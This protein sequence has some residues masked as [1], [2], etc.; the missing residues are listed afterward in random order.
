MIYY[1]VFDS[2]AQ[3]LLV[4]TIGENLTDLY[5]QSILRVKE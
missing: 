4:V 3:R 1:E 5:V 2:Q